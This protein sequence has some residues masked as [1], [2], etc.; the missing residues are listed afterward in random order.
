MKFNLLRHLRRQST[1]TREGPGVLVP[2]FV[3]LVAVGLTPTSPKNQAKK[4]NIQTPPKHKTLNITEGGDIKF[5]YN[6]T[7]IQKLLK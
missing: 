2:L 3:I 5:S 6:L 1:T 4:K 7:R